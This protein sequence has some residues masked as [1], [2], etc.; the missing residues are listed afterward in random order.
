MSDLIEQDVQELADELGFD[1]KKLPY[2]F[3]FRIGKLALNYYNTTNTVVI[4]KPKSVQKVKKNIPFSK[5]KPMLKKLKGEI[6]TDKSITGEQAIN[7]IMSGVEIKHKRVGES[8]W[9]MDD[10]RK[11][12]LGSFLNKTFVFKIGETK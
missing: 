2:G 5:I 11:L 1:L 3:Q 6:D 8:E 9:R 4:S 10:V 7:F 12:P